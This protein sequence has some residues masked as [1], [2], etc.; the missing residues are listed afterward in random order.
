MAQS[1]SEGLKA[2]CTGC[3]TVV[4]SLIRWCES[5][6]DNITGMQRLIILE[7]DYCNG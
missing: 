7:H 5:E 4:A 3:R 2:L 1:G 6:G